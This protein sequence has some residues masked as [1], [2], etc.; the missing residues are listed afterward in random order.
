M[1]VGGLPA[2]LDARRLLGPG[3]W[4]IADEAGIRL[5]EANLERQAAASLVERL[6]NIGFGGNALRVEVS[7]PVGRTAVR[8]AKTDEARRR[9]KKTVGFVNRTTW[10]DEAEARYSLT[11]EALAVQM[12]KRATARG[13]RRVVD[14]CV[15]AG[16]NAIAFAREGL[17]VVAIDNDRVRLRMAAHNAEVYDVA[18]RIRFVEGD[19]LSV[20]P[21]LEADLLFLDP[22]WGEHYDRIRTSLADLPLAEAVLRIVPAERFGAVWL[23]APPSFDPA[24]VAHAWVDAYF[25]EAE[26]DFDRVKLL[27]IEL[28]AKSG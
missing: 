13:I 7:P 5:A 12:A 23:K 17:D 8:A 16:G 10:L 14:A 20:L 18:E 26:G 24:S 2:W 1:R 27:L 3:D 11:P 21:S 28:G 19:V 9:R 22:P 25:G 6:R 4:R 15:G